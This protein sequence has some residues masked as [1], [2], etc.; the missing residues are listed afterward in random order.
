MEETNVV[1]ARVRV[2]ERRE[3]GREKMET[4]KKRKRDDIRRR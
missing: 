2:E 3:R 1:R 4:G